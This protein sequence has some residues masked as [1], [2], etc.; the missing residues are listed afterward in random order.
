MLS[1]AINFTKARGDNESTESY[2]KRFSAGISQFQQLCMSDK[3]NSSVKMKIFLKF[4]KIDPNS[5]ADIIARWRDTIPFLRGNNLEN[6]VNLLKDITQSSEFS[7]EERIIT[8]VS[9]YNHHMYDICYDCFLFIAKDE[10]LD[11][12]H[13]IESIKFLY[14]TEDHDIWDTIVKILISIIKDETICS[15]KRYKIISEFSKTTG[16]VSRYNI[17]K[18]NVPYSPGFIAPIQFAY[19]D[20]ENNC[21][22]M[23]ILSGQHLIQM[24]FINKK[25]I[26]ERLLDIARNAEDEMTGADAADVVIRVGDAE[27]SKEAMGII[28]N[29]GFSKIKRNKDGELTEA[30]KTVYSDSQNVH[31]FTEQTDEFLE[32][33]SENVYNSKSFEQVNKIVSDI[34]MATIKDIKIRY[35]IYESLSRIDLDTAVFTSNN[36]SLSDIFVKIWDIIETDDNKDQLETRMI[37][38]LIE[39]S[40]TCSSGHVVRFINVLAGDKLNFTITW[41]QQIIANVVGRI[42]AKIRDCEISEINEALSIAN[43]ELATEEETEIYNKFIKDQLEELYNPLHDEFKEFVSDD[44][45]SQAFEK[46]KKEL[47]C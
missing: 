28:K 5:A 32:K 25:V 11:Y 14:N 38:E 36:L 12:T 16:I 24:K 46:A 35:K 20:N 31:Y 1:S 40:D 39:M 2:D 13:R 3:I 45:F 44:E 29:L 6:T 37:E 19:F 27:Y 21:D 9:L 7:G 17:N 34:V 42:N 23:R 22:R 15:K 30:V 43:T 33:L 4:K 41:E 8:A 10:T 47:N 26:T 18:M